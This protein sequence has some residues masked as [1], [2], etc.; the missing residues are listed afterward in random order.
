MLVNRFACVST[1]YPVKPS[2]VRYSKNSVFDSEPKVFSS[3]PVSLMTIT[4]S[5]PYSSN[6]VSPAMRSAASRV[7]SD[8]SAFR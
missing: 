3:S 7:A 5:R 2:S 8:T 6:G 4:E 1:K